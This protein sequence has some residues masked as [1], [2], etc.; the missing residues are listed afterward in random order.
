MVV[1]AIVHM[2][3]PRTGTSAIQIM[4][5][6]SRDALERQGF[7]YNTTFGRRS[8]QASLPARIMLS[9]LDR[10]AIKRRFPM[11]LMHV[12][13]DEEGLRKLDGALDQEIAEHPG[14]TFIFSAEDLSVMLAVDGLAEPMTRYFSERFDRVR[15]VIYLRRQ[16]R[17]IESWLAQRAK[18]GTVRSFDATMERAIEQGDY[19]YH[20]NLERLARHVGRESIVVR[21]FER[22]ALHGRDAAFNFADVLGLDAMTLER[23]DD[24][25]NAS[26]DVQSIGYVEHMARHVAAEKDGLVTPAWR[27]IYDTISGM[28]QQGEPLR[29]SQARAEAFVARFAEENAAVARAYLGREDGTL[30]EEPIEGPDEDSVPRI[31]L[32]R[33]AQITA[34]IV[35]RAAASADASKPDDRDARIA[36]LRRRLAE[37]NARAEAL[38]TA[39]TSH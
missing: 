36:F 1:D 6:R 10:D 13:E 25:V 16:D 22:G 15:Y 19:L 12:P 28:G 21:P 37:A 14:R 23:A 24:T 8:S 32:D 33:M 20:R 35:E 27:L 4:L 39:S 34:R 18:V 29:M 11:L 17:H 5:A 2:G 38:R 31:D 26:W 9:R 3:M 7:R 30:F